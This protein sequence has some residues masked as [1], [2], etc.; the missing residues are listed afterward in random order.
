[1]KR[2]LTG[3]RST[4]TPHLGN[5]LSVI[6]PSIHIANKSEKYSSFIF[7]ADLHS[8]IKLDNR[9]KIRNNI[10]KILSTWL[11]FGLNIDNCLIYRQSDI[12]EV[13]ELAWYLSCCFPYQRLKLSH[14]FKKEIKHKKKQE[15]KINVGL[16]SYPILMAADILLYDAKIIPV[17]KDQLQHIEITRFIANLFNK[18]I[19]KNIFVLPQALLQNEAMCVPGIDGNKMSKSKNNYIN[20]FSSKEILKKQIMHIQ[21]DNK[22]FQE[23]KNPD[24]DCIM[25]LY[26]LVSNKHEINNMKKKYLNGRY[27]YS[28]AKIELYHRIN[29]KFDKEREKFFHFMKNEQLL[30]KILFCGAKK[31]KHIAINKLNIV[32]KYLNLNSLFYFMS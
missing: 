8:L 20:I 15:S 26:K 29:Q 27:G 9:N 18:K 17:G 31:V 1:M 10:Y 24:E 5:I 12:P 32:R 28:D 25:S 30:D 6:I 16:F 3:I 11:A 4:G 19:G 7:I 2:M 14:S 13:T 21:T 23:K 22:S